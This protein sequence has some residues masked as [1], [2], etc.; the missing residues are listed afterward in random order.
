MEKRSQTAEIARTDSQCQGVGARQ[1]SLFP[2]PQG[3]GYL[4]IYTFSETALRPSENVRRRFPS[5]PKISAEQ[6]DP[7]LQQL[8]E[9]GLNHIWLR[10]AKEI[11][12]DN[13]VKMWRILDEYDEIKKEHGAIS[14]N[15]R[16]YRAQQRYQ[17]DRFFILAKHHSGK[18]KSAR[19]KTQKQMCETVG[20]SHISRVEKRITIGS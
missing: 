5:C 14:T 2:P 13:F 16:A 17:R 11:G 12:Y 4:K 9:I 19:Q 1:P 7:R 15:I 6:N 18:V 10:V 20:I 3:G 8:R